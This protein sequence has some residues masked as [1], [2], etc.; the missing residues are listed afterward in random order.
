MQKYVIRK[1][2]W[3][4][5]TFL[6]NYIFCC[7]CVVYINAIQEDSVGYRDKIEKYYNERT[8]TSKQLGALYINQKFHINAAAQVVLFHSMLF[9]LLTA[10]LAFACS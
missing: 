3:G 8:G 1:P 4:S 6:S 9:S 2:N 10:K 7:K 5:F